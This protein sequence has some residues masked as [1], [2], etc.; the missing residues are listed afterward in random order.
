MSEKHVRCFMSQLKYFQQIYGP[1]NRNGL[2][3]YLE[4]CIIIY[5]ASDKIPGT[6]LDRSWSHDAVKIT[7]LGV[8]F[9]IGRV[10]GFEAGGKQSKMADND[11]VAMDFSLRLSFCVDI[12][13]V[14]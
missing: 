10:I 6:S 9:R 3:N 7:V 4:L 8:E 14:L 5:H 2:K 12:L 11:L 13:P 1:A